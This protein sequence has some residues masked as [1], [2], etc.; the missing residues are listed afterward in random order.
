[1]YIKDFDSFL[2]NACVINEG[3]MEGLEGSARKLQGTMKSIYGSFSDN[4][5]KM[6][7]ASSS[8]NTSNVNNS[9]SYQPSITIINQANSTSPSEIARKA[10][11]TQRQLAMEWGV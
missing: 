4:S 1:M 3:L 9:R 6:L 8:S 5:E 11:Q 2:S 10:L 7:T